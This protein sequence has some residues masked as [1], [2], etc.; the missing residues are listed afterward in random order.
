M[1]CGT[2][3]LVEISCPADCV[4]LSAAR[5]HPA[6]VVVR[7][8]QRDLTQF[9]QALRDLN[10]RQSRLFVAINTAIVRYQPPDLH[11]IVDEDVIEASAALAA[12][13][14]TATRG[15]IYEHR[16]ATRSAGRLADAIRQLLAEAGHH[17]GTAFERD[18][19]VVLRRIEQTARAAHDDDPGNRRAYLAL[20]DRVVRA[21]PDGGGATDDETKGPRLIVP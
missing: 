14:E 13:F 2:K 20:L 16:P 11:A 1:C 6:A 17:G 4:Y 5:E 15:V 7:R 21:D 8:Q 12:T 18:A 9:M 19:A 3:R 10:E